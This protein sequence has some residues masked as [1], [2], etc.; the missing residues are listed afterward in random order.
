M[1]TNAQRAGDFSAAGLKTRFYDPLTTT[2]SGTRKQISCNGVLNVI[3]PSRIVPQATAVLAYYPQANVGATSFQAVPSQ[4]IDWDQFTIRIDH[5]INTNN[6]LFGRWIY[7]NNRESDPNFS[8]QLKTASLTSNGQD[9]A[10]GLITNIGAN[11]VQDFRAHYLPS[12]VRLTA[13]LQGPDF[14][15]ANNIQGFTGL[16]RPDTGSPFRLF[17]ER[18]L[19]CKGPRSINVQSR[20]TALHLRLRITS[21]LSRGVSL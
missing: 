2:P 5:Q 19:L 20:R 15:A 16:A 3:C 8:P 18:R 7:I 14:N 13:F 17:L 11:K 12:H 6:R 1:P 4:A 21:H 10:V 9:I